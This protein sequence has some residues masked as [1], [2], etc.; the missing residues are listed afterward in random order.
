MRLAWAAILG[1]AAGWPAIGQGADTNA[2]CDRLATEREPAAFTCMAQE[3]QAATGSPSPDAAFAA[4][5]LDYPELKYEHCQRAFRRENLNYLL[6]YCAEEAWAT[7]RAQCERNVDT[8]SP[9][10]VEYCNVFY[11]GTAPT[12]GN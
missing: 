4:C 8:V 12:Y 1:L 3:L 10:Y 5:G 11:S 9:R 7:A 6:K 2:L